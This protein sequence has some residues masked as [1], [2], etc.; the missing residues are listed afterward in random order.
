LDALAVA[1]ADGCLVVGAGSSR[2]CEELAALAPLSA[3]AGTERKLQVLSLSS[4]AA[5]LCAPDSALKRQD[6][7]AVGDGCLRILGLQA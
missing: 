4:G 2:H 7:L 6:W 3:K 1:D 5:W